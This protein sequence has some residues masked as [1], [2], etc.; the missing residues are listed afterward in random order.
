[1]RNQK[2]DRPEP[3]FDTAAFSM[4]LS[5]HRKTTRRQILPE[6]FERFFVESAANQQ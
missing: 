5:V 4:R 1:M 3:D 6:D 2:I